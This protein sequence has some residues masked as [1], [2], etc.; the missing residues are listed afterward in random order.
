MFVDFD[1][2]VISL[3]DR[4]REPGKYISAGDLAHESRLGYYHHHQ[5]FP[6]RF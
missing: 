5:H 2:L 3:I 1:E 6:L 4:D